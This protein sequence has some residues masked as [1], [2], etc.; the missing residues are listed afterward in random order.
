MK[1]LINR[2]QIQLLLVMVIA[3][4]ANAQDSLSQSATKHKWSFLIEP[5][6][7]FPNMNGT[8]AV[9]NLPD[10]SVDA[11]PEDIYNKLQIGAMLF[12]EAR[13]DKWAINSDLIYMNLEQEAESSN[14][15]NS[16]DVSAKQF[17]LEVAGLRRILPWLEIG[18]G[19][20]VNSIESSVDLVV[21]NIGP[22]P[23]TNA[24]SGNIS[25]TWIDPMLIARI[26]S[27]SSDK[28]IYE[29]RGEIGGF[30]IGSDLAWQ[31][32]A[33]GGYRI[34]K[35]F[36]VAAG[37]RVI[38]LDYTSGSGQDTFKYDVMTFGPEIRIGFNF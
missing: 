34:T 36:Q 38:S 31:L 9:G 32:H 21:N 26:K 13:N 30:G 2:I 27:N 33:S 7:M 22:L 1:I 18:A 25:E 16:G 24:R 37:Y 12:L 29:F 4:S 19:G 17:A 10:V 23:I 35:L 8:T 5:Y 3:F 11:S 15:I 20:I 6:L 28:F 14:L